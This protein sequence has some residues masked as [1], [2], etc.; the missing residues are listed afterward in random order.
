MLCDSAK[1]QNYK[2][3]ETVVTEGDKG[4]AF[5][6]I[7]EGEVEVT[8]DRNGKKVSLSILK[9]GAFFGEVAVLTQ[10]VRTATVSASQDTSLVVF[11]QESINVVLKKF[12][13]VKAILQ[14]ILVSRAQKTIGNL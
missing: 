8:I 12:P 13:R 1:L 11:S 3:G 5:Y 14:A 9:R 10:N 4:D 2:A 6:L 7:K